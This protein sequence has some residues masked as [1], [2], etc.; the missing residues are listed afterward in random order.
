MIAT[1]NQFRRS[2][3]LGQV[4]LS[5]A[6]NKAASAY[7]CEMATTGNFGHVG[8]NGSTV[9]TRVSKSGYGRACVIAENIAW[10]YQENAVMQGWETSAK[11]RANMTHRKV[12]EIGIGVAYNG[13]TPYW[14]MTLASKC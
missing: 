7:A 11:H 1:T 14:V 12:K 13:T 6:L 9:K 5:S 8:R 3:G 2:L 10:G 4:R